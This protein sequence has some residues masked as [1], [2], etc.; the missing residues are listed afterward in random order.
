[1]TGNTFFDACRMFKH[2]CAFVDCATFCETEPK[3]IKTGVMTHMAADIVNSAFACE[4]FIKSLLIYHGLAIDDIRGHKLKLLWSK[5][6]TVDSTNATVIEQKMKDFFE[7]ENEDMFDELLDN[8]SDAFEYWRY[9]YEK[10]GGKIHVQFLRIFRE[11]LR[12][13]CCETYYHMTWN[14]YLNRES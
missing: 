1:M 9:I 12:G 11:M 3:N 13:V 5:Y 2:A 4:V 14:D 6:R 10:H 7:S 8:I